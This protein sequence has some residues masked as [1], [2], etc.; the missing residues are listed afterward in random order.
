MLKTRKDFNTEQE[1]K[2]YTKT[3]DFLLNYSWKG[4][5]KEQIIHE[6]AL[7]KYEQKY[8]DE[9]MKEL[10]KKDM[11]RGMELDR[12]ILRKLD[13]DT[14]DGWNEEGVVFIERER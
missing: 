14:D 2:A 13:E 8:L 6:M 7:P 3:S 5:T 1:Y 12:L 10:E 4:K 11:Y 9:S